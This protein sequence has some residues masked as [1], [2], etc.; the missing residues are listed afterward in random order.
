LFCFMDVCLFGFE[1]KDAIDYYSAMTQ[2]T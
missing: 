2:V 1:L